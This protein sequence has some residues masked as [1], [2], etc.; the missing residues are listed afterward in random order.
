LT[1]PVAVHARSRLLVTLPDLGLVTALDPH[2]LE[3]TNTIRVGSA[4]FAIAAD[5]TGRRV[6]VANLDSNSISII[7]GASLTVIDE[8]AVPASPFALA[9]ND[10][11][12][13]LFVIPLTG[14]PM[15]L[16]L[17]TGRV[18]ANVPLPGDPESV[19]LTAD[20][21]HWIVAEDEAAEVAFVDTTTYAVSTQVPVGRGAFGLAVSGDRAYV[22]NIHDGT[23]AVVDTATPAR[24]ALFPIP[25]SYPQ[26]L[27]TPVEDFAIA[28]DGHTGFISQTGVGGTPFAIV[29]VDLATGMVVNGAAPS[30]GF[31]DAPTAM[32]VDPTG[33][34]L[35][36]LGEDVEEAT[37]VGIPE[38]GWLRVYD[39]ASLDE[40]RNVRWRQFP[41]RMLFLSTT[42]SAS[43][44]SGCQVDAGKSAPGGLAAALLPLVLLVPVLN[45]AA[46]RR[47]S[48]AR[49]RPR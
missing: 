19:V 16:D 4:P 39:G 36:V 1:L 11:D 5:R 26:F 10:D 23:L 12:S 41:G 43:S 35:F 17:P 44:T 28:P 15:V 47:A 18:I 2:S 33:K 32:V 48:A 3:P 34:S 29:A 7:D 21:S 49:S 30:G 13:A 24:L 40:R 27:A 8:L 31:S 25:L 6:Y 42:N 45:R 20:G 38:P 37:F 46:A 9:A 22:T 14:P